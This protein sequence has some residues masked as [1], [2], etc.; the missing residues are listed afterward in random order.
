MWSGINRRKFPR[1]N[2]PCK[3]TVKRKDQSDTL[4]T[5]TEN[6]GIGGICVILPKDLGI[7][8]PVE[9]QLDLLDAKPV[10]ECDGA[11]VWI[12]EKKDMQEKRFDTGI[13][14]T[15]LKRKDAERINNIV[16]MVLKEG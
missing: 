10:I 12:V 14:F 11:I 4:S 9:V 16:D 7:F 13:E 5:Y 3:I 6:I 15:N 8:A 1:A 2:Y